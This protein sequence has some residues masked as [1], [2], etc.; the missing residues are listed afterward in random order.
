MLTCLQTTLLSNDRILT[1]F[2][3]LRNGGA[4]F[5]YWDCVGIRL[6]IKKEGIESLLLYMPVGLTIPVIVLMN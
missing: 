5:A 2:S 6:N 4:V 1:Q 3:S